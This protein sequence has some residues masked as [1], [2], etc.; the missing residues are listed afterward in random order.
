MLVKDM[1][2]EDLGILI[3]A[4]FMRALR[5][6]GMAPEPPEIDLSGYKPSTKKDAPVVAEAVSTK[7]LG[8]M[9]RAIVKRH[10]NEA[11]AKIREFLVS[12][13]GDHV[14]RLQHLENDEQRQQTA[15]F[16]QELM[17]TGGK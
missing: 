12:S 6:A 15:T 7:Q 14:E 8:D 11:V 17:H 4:A 16:L 13:F 2:A 9:A 3:E 1:T 10:G 5:S